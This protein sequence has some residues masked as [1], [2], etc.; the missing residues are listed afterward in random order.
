MASRMTLSSKTGPCPSHRASPFNLSEMSPMSTRPCSYNG[1]QTIKSH[2]APAPKSRSPVFGLVEIL[3][4][5]PLFGCSPNIGDVK[6]GGGLAMLWWSVGLKFMFATSVIAGGEL[7]RRLF[8]CRSLFSS[9]VFWSSCF[10]ISFCDAVSDA[11]CSNVL[12]LCSSSLTC[13]S[14]RSRNARCLQKNSDLSLV[15]AGERGGK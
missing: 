11:C 6:A 9:L 2:A 14:L 13:R 4:S 15:A 8:S 7:P 12:S 5:G 1:W 3:C 10:S